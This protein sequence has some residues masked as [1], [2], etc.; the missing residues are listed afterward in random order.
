[1]LFALLIKTSF[2]KNLP[3]YLSH[4]LMERSAWNKLLILFVLFCVCD[5]VTVPKTI[6]LG[7][8]VPI[9]IYGIEYNDNY[10]GMFV[11]RYARNNK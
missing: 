6:T 11:V 4:C 10:S 5:T 2:E 8:P 7:A 9:T 1:M 3:D